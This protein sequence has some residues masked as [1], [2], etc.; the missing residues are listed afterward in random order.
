MHICASTCDRRGSRSDT[1]GAPTGDL[2]RIPRGKGSDASR[3][4]IG[5]RESLRELRAASVS[6]QGPQDSIG[7]GSMLEFARA[8]AAVGG[9]PATLEKT[10]ILATYM[11]SLEDAD[12]RRAAT[13][14]SGRAFG[15]SQRR[16]LGLG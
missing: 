9:T 15:Q 2:S 16:T 11:R 14:M 8:A 7:S 12:L 6:S 1:R 5:H 4:T 3:I 13:F 10:R